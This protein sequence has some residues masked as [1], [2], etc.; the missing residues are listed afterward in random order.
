MNIEK[1]KRRN[2]DKGIRQERTVVSYFV[3]TE[4]GDL[5]QVYLNAF[6]GITSITRRQLNILA[7]KFKNTHANPKESRGGFPLSKKIKSEEVTTSI[8]N[9]I[10]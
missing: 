2:R 6:V 5:I 3:P 10:M 8:K 9:H 1:P 7:S 4:K